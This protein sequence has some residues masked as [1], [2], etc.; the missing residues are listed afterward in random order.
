ML[1]IG[2]KDSQYLGGN[3]TGRGGISEREYPLNLRSFKEKVNFYF[4]F[5]ITTYVGNIIHQIE[6]FPIISEE[7]SDKL[8]VKKCN[9][10][11][12]RT[13]FFHGTKAA[14]YLQSS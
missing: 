3:F 14:N 12:L 1:V 13:Q 5:L 4:I 10:I 8:G 9:S 6:I 11:L 2:K 7:K